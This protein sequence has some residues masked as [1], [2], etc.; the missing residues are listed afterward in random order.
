[1]NGLRLILANA[2]SQGAE[3]GSPITLATG[4]GYWY[5]ILSLGWVNYGIELRVGLL[6]LILIGLAGVTYFLVWKR[7]LPVMAGWDTTEITLKYGDFI[8]QKITPNFDTIRIAYQAWIE[9]T[10]RKVGLPFDEEH[11]VIAEVY[12]SWFELFGVLRDLSKSVPAHRLRECP[13][14]QKLVGLLVDV[15]NRGLRPHL[16]RWQAKFRRWYEAAKEKEEKRDRTPQEI[17]RGYPEHRELVQDLKAVNAE[18]VKFAGALQEL[19]EG[20]RSGK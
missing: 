8:E 18:F 5:D 10:T 13:D 17:Q 2:Q 14:T 20:R 4:S 11:D 1:M 3:T 9:I 19:A 12:D 15:L 6:G 7:F 16:T